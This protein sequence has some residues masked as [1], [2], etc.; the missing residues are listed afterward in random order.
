MRIFFL[1]SNIPQ[2]PHDT[3]A[4]SVLVNE[5]I[6]QFVEA[7]HEVVLQLILPEEER[8]FADDERAN[9]DR[10][11]SEHRVVILPPLWA[12]DVAKLAGAAKLGRWD[13]SRLRIYPYL[14]LAPEIAARVKSAGATLA[15]SM[16]SG[17]ALPAASEIVDIPN[18]IFYGNLDYKP[19]EA[20]LADQALFGGPRPGW[21]E[22]FRQARRLRAQ[23][24]WFLE[25]MAGYDFVWNSSALDAALLRELGIPQARYLQNM[26]PLPALEDCTPERRRR[27]QTDPLKICASIGSL[28]GTANTYGLNFLGRELAPLLAEKLPM[29]FDLHV[30]GSRQPVAAVAQALA[31]PRIQQRGFVADIDGE[32]LE[33]PIFLVC[34]NAGRYKAQHTRFLHAWSLDACIIAH[35]DNRLTMPELEHDRNVLLAAD[36]GEFAH[37]IERAAGDRGLRERIGRGGRETFLRHCSPSVVMQELLAQ[38]AVGGR[39]KQAQPVSS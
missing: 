22:R 31:H 8:P 27:E 33:S 7:G 10:L 24:R 1:A 34:N 20:R 35:A 23:R 15:F 5:A 19:V 14:R 26:W 32:I 2:R 37:W 39:Q 30:F 4:P 16:Y 18:G 13:V 12:T 11:E 38:I 17:P 28:Q 29:P 9:L 36:A 6:G 25:M 21:I 3:R